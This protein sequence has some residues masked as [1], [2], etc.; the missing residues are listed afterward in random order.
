MKILS[1]NKNELTREQ[2]LYIGD[3]LGY[4][5]QVAVN[6]ANRFILGCQGRLKNWN[7]DEVIN[8]GDMSKVVKI[9]A[10]I[11]QVWTDNHTCVGFDDDNQLL[12]KFGNVIKI[13]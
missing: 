3:L 7:Y 1:I 4:T 2:L 9:I 10:Y 5:P 12:N 8:F 11:E 6:K 13:N